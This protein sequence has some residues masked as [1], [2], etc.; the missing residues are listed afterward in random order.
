MNSISRK[1][2]TKSVISKGGI[3]GNNLKSGDKSALKYLE[4]VNIKKG[5][6]NNL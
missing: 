2:C 6:Q 1:G 4:R 3:F 5:T